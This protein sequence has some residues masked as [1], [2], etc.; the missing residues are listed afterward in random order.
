MLLEKEKVVYRQTKV[1]E[2]QRQYA[3]GS[4]VDA[5]GDD[6]LGGM[7]SLIGLASFDIFYRLFSMFLPCSVLLVGCYVRV[8]CMLCTLNIPVPVCKMLCS[9]HICGM[10]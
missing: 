9:L 3:E 1:S 4:G 7:L 2:G 10:L 8:C 5:L 6:A